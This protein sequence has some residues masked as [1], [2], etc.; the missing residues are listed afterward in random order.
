MLR[1]T[2]YEF[3]INHGG[4]FTSS[5]QYCQKRSGL[6]IHPINEVTHDFLYAELERNKVKLKSRLV[7]IGARR[8]RNSTVPSFHKNR[9]Q[10]NLWKCVNGKPVNKFLWASDQPN[11]YNGQQNCMV[12]DG[13]RQWYWNDVT[14]DLGKFAFSWCSSSMFFRGTFS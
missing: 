6:L 10:N 14:C 7:W 5:A 4:S 1:K 13:G 12:L 11:N 8:E 9:I 2:D 3:Q